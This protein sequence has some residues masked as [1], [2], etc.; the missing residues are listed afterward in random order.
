MSFI[1]ISFQSM[2]SFWL[3]IFK[4]FY[5][6]LGNLIQCILVIFTLLLPLTPPRSTYLPTPSLSF[7]PSLKITHWVQFVLPIYSVIPR[8]LEP[9]WPSGATPL[10]KMFSLREAINCLQLLTHGG[11]GLPVFFPWEGNIL[12]DLQSEGSG[13]VE[14]AGVVS[15]LM[16]FWGPGNWKTSSSRWR[17][18]SS[19]SKSHCFFISAFAKCGQQHYQY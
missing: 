7:P 14:A 19:Q 17:A 16:G 11:G 18:A 13:K 8:P 9:G 1:N 2:V 10:K 12:K 5:L 15:S 3:F 4:I 6:F